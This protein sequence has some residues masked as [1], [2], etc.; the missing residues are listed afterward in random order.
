M[1]SLKVWALC[2]N[3]ASLFRALAAERAGLYT[4]PGQPTE[5]L[6][7]YSTQ[8]AIWQIGVG[9]PQQH[10]TYERSYARTAARFICPLPLPLRRRRYASTAATAALPAPAAAVPGGKKSLVGSAFSLYEEGHTER[11][12]NT[13]GACRKLQLLRQM[14]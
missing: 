3:A 6:P 9:L 13:E 1:Q 10:R 11:A 8:Q 2:A 12:S 4:Y 7:P 14:S 5:V